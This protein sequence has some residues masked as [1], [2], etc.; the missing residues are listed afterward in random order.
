MCGFL[1]RIIINAVLLYFIIAELPGIFV[2]TLGGMLLGV[3]IVGIVN[4]AV[5]P[6]L[7]LTARPLNWLHLGGATFCMNVLTPLI[8]IKAL[9]GFKIYSMVS[10]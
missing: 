5:R 2:D 4:A 9:P 3:V 8:V 6:I 10:P 7:M 1:L